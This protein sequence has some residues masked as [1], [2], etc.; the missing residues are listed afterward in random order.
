MRALPFV[1]CCWYISNPL[2]NI[3]NHC[4]PPLFLSTKEL[5]RLLLMELTIDF[6]PPLSLLARPSQVTLQTTLY[7]RDEVQ[8]VAVGLISVGV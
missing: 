7:A 4:M 5:H 2:A 1:I 6:S 8:Y 3:H